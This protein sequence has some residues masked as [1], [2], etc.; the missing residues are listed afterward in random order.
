MNVW[1]NGIVDVPCLCGFRLVLKMVLLFFVMGM[2]LFWY[3]SV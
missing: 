2:L 1:Y 3:M